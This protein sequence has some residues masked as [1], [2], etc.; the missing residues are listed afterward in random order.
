VH[1]WDVAV[2]HDAEATVAPDAVELLVD[3]L[4]VMVQHAGKP[5]EEP[6]VVL[7]TTEAPARQ[8]LLQV[9]GEGVTLSQPG[10]G[11]TTEATVSLPAEA[12]VRLVYGRLDDQHTPPLD[13]TGVDLDDL[14]RAFPG[15]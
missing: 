15:F 8:L 6:V 9:G 10:D 13:I 3:T 4:E 12:F 7:V 5:L 14:R 11:A 2:M 1:T